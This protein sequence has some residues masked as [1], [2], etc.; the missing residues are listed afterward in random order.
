MTSCPRCGFDWDAP[1]AALVAS[2][3]T[4]P[5]RFDDAVVD[6]EMTELRNRPAPEVWSVIEYVGHAGDVVG[7][8][9][10][11]ILRVL[12]EDRPV[13]QAHDWALATDDRRYHERHLS[14]LLETLADHCRDLAEHL[15]ELEQAAWA[16]HGIGSEGGERSVLV[17]ARRAVHEVEH[18]LTDIARPR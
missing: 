10:Q 17:L 5:R 1:A 13:L 6:V 11:R 18:H 3:R 2:L 8:Y 12:K 14:E 4:A 7:W 15:G 9:G 16:R